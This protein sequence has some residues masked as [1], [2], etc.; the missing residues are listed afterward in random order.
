MPF[1]WSNIRVPAPIVVVNP[2]FQ[3]QEDIQEV[4][5][6]ELKIEPSLEVGNTGT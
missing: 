3:Q 6:P 1:A 5:I 2:L 4:N